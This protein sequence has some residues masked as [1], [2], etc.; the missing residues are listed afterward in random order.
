MD[1]INSDPDLEKLSPLLIS[2]LKGMNPDNGK[3][4]EKPG[5]LFLSSINKGSELGRKEI[6]SD[7][8]SLI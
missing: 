4:L 3:K 8:N 5:F 1:E 2:L 6:N 7:L